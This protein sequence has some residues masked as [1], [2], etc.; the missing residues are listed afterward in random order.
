M[1]EFL[2]VKIVH[3]QLVYDF[4]C[5]MIISKE[6]PLRQIMHGHFILKDIHFFFCEL[7]IVPIVVIVVAAITSATSTTSATAEAT[8]ATETSESSTTKSPA[9][10]STTTHSTAA[11]H[12]AATTHSA[13]M[14]WIIEVWIDWN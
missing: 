4:L 11:T 8:E 12:S 5:K 10:K 9:L 1:K 13:K 6:V 14:T 3:Y 2:I 7:V